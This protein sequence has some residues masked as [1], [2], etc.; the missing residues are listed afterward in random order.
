VQ[1]SDKSRPVLI[2]HTLTYDEI[3]SLPSGRVLDS[4]IQE[5][6]FGYNPRWFVSKTGVPKYYDDYSDSYPEYLPYF[7]STSGGR[8]EIFWIFE[9]FGRRYKFLLEGEKCWAT[10]S[11]VSVEYKEKSKLWAHGDNPSLAVCRAALLVLSEENQE[12]LL[13]W[14]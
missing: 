7:S 6:V 9:K 4:L 2:T 11:Y 14:N 13:T 1:Q 12:E 3:M 10:F 8:S 5:Y